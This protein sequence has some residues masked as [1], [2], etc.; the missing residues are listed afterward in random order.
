MRRF[1]DELTREQKWIVWSLLTL[2]LFLIFTAL[3][4]DVGLRK[5]SRSLAVGR[6]I[7]VSITLVTS[8]VRDLAC[9]ADDEVGGARCLF[10]ASGNVRAE[11]ATAD[12]TGRSARVLAPYM[13]TDNV[14][15]L[16]PG[17]FAEPAVAKR[18][19]E[20]PPT[21]DRDRLRR[22]TARCQLKLEGRVKDVAVRW[23]QQ[24][25]FGPRPEGA[26]VGKVSDCSIETA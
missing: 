15:F 11:L 2:V 3:F 16:I 17:L 5:T 14:L 12:E 10:D 18:Y 13:T 6:T 24:A 1:L 26:W 9:A 7:D 21:V 25:A 8:D 23:T 20:D 22:F 19:A 4:P